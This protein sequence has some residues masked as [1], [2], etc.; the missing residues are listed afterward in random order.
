MLQRSSPTNRTATL[1]APESVHPLQEYLSDLQSET[2]KKFP[3]VGEEKGKD[4]TNRE[5]SDPAIKRGDNDDET[6][7]SHLVGT[8]NFGELFQEFFVT[9]QK[10]LVILRSKILLN[11][12]INHNTL[13]V[14]SDLNADKLQTL[15]KRLYLF[16]I[17]LFEYRKGA[18]Y[19][20][21]RQIN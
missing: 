1:P 8:K 12:D 13:I 18:H 17:N 5:K 6:N 21:L 14:P 4:D 15:R 19:D 11:R 10:K 16:Q 20:N 7:L 3:D 2:A 9:E